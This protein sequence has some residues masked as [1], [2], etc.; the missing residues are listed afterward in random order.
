MQTVIA[1]RDQKDST[2]LTGNEGKK[3]CRIN[4]YHFCQDKS[5]ENLIIMPLIG[6]NLQ[7]IKEFYPHQVIDHQSVFAIAIRAIEELEKFH[8]TGFVH[9]DIKPENILIGTQKIKSKSPRNLE[10]QFLDI[11][12]AKSDQDITKFIEFIQRRVGSSLNELQN[13]A[14]LGLQFFSDQQQTGTFTSL[15]NLDLARENIEYNKENENKMDQSDIV[16]QELFLIDFGAAQSYITVKSDGRTQ[17]IEKQ[18]LDDIT[19]TVQFASRDQMQGFTLSRKDDLESLFY[20]ILSLLSIPLRKLVDVDLQNLI[21]KSIPQDQSKGQQDLFKYFNLKQRINEKLFEDLKIPKCLQKFWSYLKVLKFE[22]SPNYSK[23][24]EYFRS[25]IKNNQN[26]LEIVRPEILE[27]DPTWQRFCFCLQNSMRV[28]EV[29]EFEMPYFPNINQQSARQQVQ[30]E[31][32]INKSEPIMV[33]GQEV[34]SS[35][36]FGFEILDEIEDNFLPPLNNILTHTCYTK[37]S[38]LLRQKGLGVLLVAF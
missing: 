37:S 13:Q 30:S 3:V 8:E 2:N 16:Q 14:S 1:V 34:I 20:T 29:Q 10:V 35:L 27:R 38:K 25:E 22:E 33:I 12:K 23:L 21:H 26:P 4:D 24:I 36:D 31:Q 28:N 32:Q 11:P 9:G 6:S 5:E 7:Q 18:Q 15:L 17:H 19:C